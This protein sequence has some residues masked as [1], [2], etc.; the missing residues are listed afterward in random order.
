M[1]EGQAVGR[2]ILVSCGGEMI[3]LSAA[4]WLSLDGQGVECEVCKREVVVAK[5]W[6]V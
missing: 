5:I 1:Y 3:D 2:E 4:V 6:E